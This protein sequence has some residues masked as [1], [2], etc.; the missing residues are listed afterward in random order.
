MLLKDSR[1]KLIKNKITQ[2]EIIGLF[3]RDKSNG[4]V[5]E[6]KVNNFAKIFILS[7]Y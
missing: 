3:I 2:N 7:F 1:P 5:K 4:V 6:N